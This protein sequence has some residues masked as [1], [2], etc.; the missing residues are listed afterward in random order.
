MFLTLSRCG[1][2]RLPTTGPHRWRRGRWEDGHEGQTANEGGTGEQAGVAERGDGGDGDG[3]I[4]PP[5]GGAEH[6][7]Y[8]V[9]Y[10]EADEHKAREGNRRPGGADGKE[11][12]KS[13]SGAP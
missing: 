3:W 10:P 12:P 5:V 6:E 13:A 2:W 7:R 4:P 11:I 8:H 9:G 1:R